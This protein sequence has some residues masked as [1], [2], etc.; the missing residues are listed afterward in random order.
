MRKKNIVC[1]CG[2]RPEV[3]KFVSIVRALEKTDW[4]NVILVSTGQHREMLDQKLGYFGLKPKR[5]LNLMQP[6]QQLAQLTARLI[7]AIDEA[8]K[9]EAVDLI[10]VQGDTSTTLAAAMVAFFNKIPLGYIESGL[11]SGDIFHPF[12]EEINRILICRLATLNFAATEKAKQNLLAEGIRADSIYVTGNTSIDILLEEAQKPITVK[13]PIDSGKKLIFVTTHRRENFG[14][15]LVHICQGIRKFV[16]LN[17]TVQVVIPVHKNPN[18]YEV[19]HRILGNHPQVLLT[20]PLDYDQQVAL[21]KASYFIMTDSG[22]IQEEAPTFGK[23]LL[24]LR[25]N[26]DRP[27]GIEEGVAQIIGTSTDSVFNAAC[28]LLQNRALW[29]KMA[30]KTMPY[31]DGHAAERILEIIRN[32]FTISH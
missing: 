9:E 22:G 21:M 26:T 4:A 11:R 12:P 3:I 24:I 7:A 25:E 16:D 17:N 18:V 14:E 29:E 20:D 23:P 30:R 32:W 13:I 31:G 6:N 27:E 5:D 10:L 15:P 2:T 28:T 8:L 1:I 19:I